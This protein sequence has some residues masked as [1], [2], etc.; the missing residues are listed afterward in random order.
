MIWLAAERF[1]I[2]QQM[3]MKK[4][5]E[6][7]HLSVAA[8]TEILDIRASLNAPSIFRIVIVVVVKVEFH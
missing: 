3:W 6:S 1:F 5:K 7:F 4:E 2:K 8:V